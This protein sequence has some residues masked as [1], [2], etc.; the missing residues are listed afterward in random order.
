MKKEGITRVTF[1]LEDDNYQPD[2]SASDALTDEEITAR[3]LADPDAPPMTE[4]DMK[5]FR[6]AVDVRL[7]RTSLDMTQEQFARAFELSLPTVRDWEQ[8][9]TRPDQA[10]RTLLRVISHN[11]QLVR[12]AL[13]T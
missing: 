10:A 4:E 11:P 8:Q 1:P 5:H 2:W 9:R 7:I 12:Q 6:R 3:A 13:N